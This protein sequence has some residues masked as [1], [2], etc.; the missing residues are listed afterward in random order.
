MADLPM[1]FLDVPTL[2]HTSAA[3]NLMAALA[4]LVLAKAFRIAPRASWLMVAS[5]LMRVPPLSCGDCLAAAPTGLRLALP[6]L[7]LMSS[8][9][10]L[11]FALRRMVGSRVRA[12]HIAWIS[13]LGAGGIV[14]GVATGSVRA[15]QLANMLS[16]S[17]LSALAVREIWRGVGD[18]LS[19]AITA[20]TALPFA[21]LAAL[22]LLQAG[23]LLFMPGY[24][25]RLITQPHLGASRALAGLVVTVGISLSLIALMIWRLVMRIQHLTHRDPLTGA[26]NRRA[27]EQA[28]IEA[29]ANLTRGR[30]FA[31]VMIDI[32]HFKRINDE[33][34]H[35]AGDAA[36][37][38]CVALWQG[39]LRAL[40]RLGRLG[41]EEFCVLLPLEHPGDLTAAAAV[42][43][44][45]RSQL[46][47]TPLRWQDADLP[48]TA[49]FGVALPVVGDAQ[50][51]VALVRADAELYRAKSEGRNRV[52]AATHLGREAP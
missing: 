49:S 19:P 47:A 33:H 29:Q 5:H 51:E 32:D 1:E 35:A 43:E 46:A 31:L 2:L 52:C 37:L 8:V 48:L 40:D 16:M 10:L 11:L 12:R 13:V 45:L 30:G 21:A 7:M 17:V 44:R 4:W 25:D 34:G 23:L 14:A 27:F 38:H 26:L 3:F 15:P 50:G 41:G 42:A 20:C 9:V 28:L 36:L 39:A 22:S 18:R 6:E 24:V